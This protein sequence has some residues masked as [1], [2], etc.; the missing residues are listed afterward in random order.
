MATKDAKKKKK[1]GAKGEVAAADEKVESEDEAY[2][3]D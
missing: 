1:A 2:M 3:E